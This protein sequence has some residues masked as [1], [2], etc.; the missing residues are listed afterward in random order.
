MSSKR[1]SEIHALENSPFYRIGR[2]VDLVPLTGCNLK[3][4]KVLARDRAKHY[5]RK[6]QRIGEKLRSIA[7]PVGTLRTLHEELQ[8]HLNRIK[9]PAY[10]YSPRRGHTARRNAGL[11]ETSA[12]IAKLDIRQFYPST[13]SEHVFRFFRHRMDMVDDVAGLLT[14]LCTIDGRLPFG[15]PLSPVLCTLVHRDLFDQIALYCQSLSLVMSLWVD[16]ITISGERVSTK[17]LWTIRQMIHAKGLKSHKAQL[18]YTHLGAIIT[19]HYLHP[20]GMSAA[21]KHH[22]GV[23]D[24]MAA[25]DL[26][27]NSPERLRLLHS[28]IGKTNYA[29]GIYQPGSALRARLDK[30]RDWLHGERRY[31]QRQS[32]ISQPAKPISVLNDDFSLP[33]SLPDDITRSEYLSA[34]SRSVPLSARCEIQG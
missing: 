20:T 29:R 18:R 12:Q 10:L 23:R 32:F 27:P 4:I 8:S 24:A 33:W 16:D 13:T 26:T 7:C 5:W 30:R 25:L 14:K 1:K 31:I 6:E 34:L 19:G 3:T 2:Q 9:Q 15:S 21:N 11:H 17:V 22:L 28:L